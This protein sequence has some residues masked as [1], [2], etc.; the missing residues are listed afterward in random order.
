MTMSLLAGPMSPE[1]GQV[2]KDIQFTEY[3]GAAH[4]FDWRALKQPMPLPK[5]QS[6]RN[7]QLEEMDGGQIINAKTKQPFSYS[8]PCVE[9]GYTLAYN[10]K[11]SSA[12]KNAVRAL[13]IEVLKPRSGN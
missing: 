5:A 7:C 11:A 6:T 4:V 12:V 3:P 9:R 1:S 10:E 8:D 13:D 2:G